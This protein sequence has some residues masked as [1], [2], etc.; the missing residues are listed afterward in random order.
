MK[1]VSLILGVALFS[2]GIFATNN[3]IEKAEEDKKHPKLISVYCS[4][5]SYA[6]DIYDMG[7]ADNAEMASAMCDD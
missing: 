1:K 5:G 7:A 6:G 3:S 4:D 2:T